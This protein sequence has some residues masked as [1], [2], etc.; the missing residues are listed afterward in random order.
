MLR[1]KLLRINLKPLRQ[2]LRPLARDSMECERGDVVRLPFLYQ[3]VVFEK[4]LQL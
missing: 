2:L 1:L 4:V 3:R